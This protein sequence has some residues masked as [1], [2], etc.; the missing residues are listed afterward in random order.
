MTSPEARVR[1]SELSRKRPRHAQ[2]APSGPPFAPY[3]GQRASQSG[4]SRNEGIPESSDTSCSIFNVFL[5]EKVTKAGGSSLDPLNKMTA[6][7]PDLRIF[8]PAKRSTHLLMLK[9]GISIT[10]RRTLSF[11]A[12]SFI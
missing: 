8:S 5:G 1:G 9:S 12:I 2:C 11:M 4:R 10:P 7:G 6:I 3:E